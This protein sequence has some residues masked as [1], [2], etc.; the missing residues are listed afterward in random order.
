MKHGNVD[1][2]I[3]CY[4]RTMYTCMLGEVTM[5]RFLIPY[6]TT[7]WQITPSA[8]TL[9]PIIRTMKLYKRFRPYTYS[10][11]FDTSYTYKSY[12]YNY[13]QGFFTK[14][15]CRCHEIDYPPELAYPREYSISTPIYPPPRKI[16]TDG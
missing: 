15:R 1:I 3:S 14:N 9:S 13:T 4:I 6:T 7:L 11:P 5:H 10:F 16:T 12:M 2:I 8:R